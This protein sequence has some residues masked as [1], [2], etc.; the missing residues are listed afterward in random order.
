MQSPFSKK[1]S[2]LICP[3]HC[4]PSQPGD[5][6]ITPARPATSAN[7]GNSRHTAQRSSSNR[8]LNTQKLAIKKMYA[9][10]LACATIRVSEKGQACVA[11]V[12][13]PNN[14]QQNAVTAYQPNTCCERN[15]N[16]INSARNP[17]TADTTRLMKGRVRVR[18]CP[19]SITVNIASGEP[20]RTRPNPGVC[21]A[22]PATRTHSTRPSRKCDAGSSQ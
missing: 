2:E 6:T 17:K 9:R 15:A 5:N 21:A 3:A 22:T 8:Q 1:T 12:F 13:T 7:K 10:V 16:Q 11:R 19:C 18:Q 4:S 20:S 14:T